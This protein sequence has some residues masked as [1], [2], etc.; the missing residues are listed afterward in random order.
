MHLTDRLQEG[1]IKWNEE[2]MDHQATY[3]SLDRLRVMAALQMPR[4]LMPVTARH[5]LG[6]IRS[7]DI[8]ICRGKRTSVRAMLR[9]VRLLR[10]CVRIP[11]GVPGR[12]HGLQEMRLTQQQHISEL[13]LTLYP[14]IDVTAEIR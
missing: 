3:P 10:G 13:F 5:I 2:I 6:I 1:R 4:I 12:R 9:E 7:F 14:M 11:V 8:A